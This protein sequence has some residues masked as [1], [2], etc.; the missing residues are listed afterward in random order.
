MAKYHRCILSR[1]YAC[2][3]NDY[4]MLLMGVHKLKQGSASSAYK[5]LTFC[6]S[7]WKTDLCVMSCTADW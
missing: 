5:K 7:F 1:K 3:E 2:S 6:S 4:R